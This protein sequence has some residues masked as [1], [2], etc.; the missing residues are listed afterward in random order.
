MLKNVKTDIFIY[1]NLLFYFT[2][3]YDFFLIYF[4]FFNLK[5]IYIIIFFFLLVAFLAG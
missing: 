5:K 4:F 1:L 2:F 3:L